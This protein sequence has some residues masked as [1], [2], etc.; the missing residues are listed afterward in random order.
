MRLFAALAL[1]VAANTFGPTACAADRSDEFVYYR[2]A[3][4]TAAG[5][6][7]LGAVLLAQHLGVSHVVAL[8]PQ[9]GA[10]P[11]RGRV[12]FERGIANRARERVIAW[13]RGRPEVV[14]AGVEKEPVWVAPGDQ[15]R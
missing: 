14:A 8:G 10:A 4:M 5:A 3:P 1:F 15:R 2:T 6:D 9:A 12:A 7:S 13:L 11:R